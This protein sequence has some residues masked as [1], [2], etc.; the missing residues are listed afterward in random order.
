MKPWKGAMIT[1]GLWIALAGGMAF[2]STEVIFVELSQARKDRIHNLAGQVGGIGA[3]AFG[4]LMFRRL[5][6]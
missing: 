2:L 1:A 3:V 4:Y 6:S 5:E